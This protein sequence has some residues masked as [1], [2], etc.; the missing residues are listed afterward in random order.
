MA[1]SL[2]GT[3]LTIGIQM[4]KMTIPSIIALRE[5]PVVIE[6][7]ARQSFSQWGGSLTARSPAVHAAITSTLAP[8]LSLAPPSIS[9]MT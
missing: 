2:R 1:Q 5:E 9:G 7:G 6:Q 8:T 4:H 3:A